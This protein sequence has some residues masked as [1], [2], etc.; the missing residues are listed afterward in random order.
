MRKSARA[1]NACCEVELVQQADAAAAWDRAI[2]ASHAAWDR[3]YGAALRHAS[4][5]ALSATAAERWDAVHSPMMAKG[6]WGESRAQMLALL[7]Y[8]TLLGRLGLDD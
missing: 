7:E 5:G 4:A 6:D 8:W 3:G 1:E 2:V